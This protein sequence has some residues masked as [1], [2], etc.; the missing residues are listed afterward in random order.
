MSEPTEKPQKAH[1][2]D[3]TEETRAVDP[4]DLN[5]TG[6]FVGNPREIIDNPAVTPETVNIGQPADALS[7]LR[8]DL[9]DEE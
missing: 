6:G 9:M 4:R 3:R 2:A 8:S 1:E 7:D 5:Y